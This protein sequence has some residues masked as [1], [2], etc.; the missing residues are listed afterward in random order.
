MNSHI[1]LRTG[2]IE[3][4]IYKGLPNNVYILFIVN[5]INRLGDFVVP[6]LAMYLTKKLGYSAKSASVLVTFIV[7]LQIPGSMLGGI[8]SDSWSRKK[9]YILAQSLSGICIIACA[10]IT[11]KLWI[12]TFLFFSAFF[13]ANVKPT[14]NTML[15]DY[16]PLDK[17]RIGQSLLYLGVNL[18]VSI[19]TVLAGFMFNHYL[20]MFF[21]FDALTSF[22]AVF[23][24]AYNLKDIKIK[25][26]K[27]EL[28]TGILKKEQKKEAPRG[29]IG[30]LISNYQITFFLLI[31]LLYSFIYAQNSFSLPLTLNSIFYEKGPAFYGYLMSINAITVVS[32]TAFVTHLTRKN[33]TLIN[34]VLGGVFYTI[35]FGMLGISKSFFLFLLST[36]LW[37]TGEILN[38]TNF[39]VYL[40][41]NSEENM[42]AR[43]SSL[44]FVCYSIGRSLGVFTMGSY[45]SNF[46][47]VT[48]WPVI[49][50]LGGIISVV[51]LMFYLRTRGSSE[52]C[53][54]K[55][56]SR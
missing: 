10:F 31:Y 3:M 22:I 11:S 23:L 27:P 41:N 26:G 56:I 33:P 17:R 9:T 45:I 4:N 25:E 8:I 34:I 30:E 6:F 38:S 46:G 7:L 42:R 44:M 2:E 37:T 51:M 43:Y 12:V 1:E 55:R 53:Y 14:I 16:I 20:K 28:Q 5:I 47:L 40:M 18:G 48:V 24:V 35:G 54:N 29:F 52:L 21:I 36:V 13:S 49:M 39:G 50:L 15:Y 19:G 32:L